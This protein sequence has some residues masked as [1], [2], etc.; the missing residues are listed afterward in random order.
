MLALLVAPKSQCSWLR[1]LESF[2]R[3]VKD[4]LEG[5]LRYWTEDRCAVIED[6]LYQICP[7]TSVQ[8]E[9][10]ALL[11]GQKDRRLADQD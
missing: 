8:R 2:D 10:L 4:Y 3:L 6:G 11:C 1:M 9:V 7:K 5:E